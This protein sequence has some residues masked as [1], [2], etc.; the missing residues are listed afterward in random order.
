MK[1]NYNIIED[2]N[3]RNDDRCGYIFQL[4]TPLMCLNLSNTQ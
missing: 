1:S 4:K 2:N 3:D